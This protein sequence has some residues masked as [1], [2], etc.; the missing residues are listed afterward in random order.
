[1]AMVIEQL[2][3]S[4]E[5]QI[6][7]QLF[8]PPESHH[9][10]QSLENNN[11]QSKK[12]DHDFDFDWANSDRSNVEDDDNYS[13]SPPL[14]DG[15]DSSFIVTNIIMKGG[16]GIKE[17]QIIGD[18]KPGGKLLVCGFT[19]RG[20][21]RCMFQWVRYHRDVTFEYIEGATNPEYVVSADDV[22]KLIAVE[23]I[24]MDDHGRRVKKI[25]KSIIFKFKIYTNF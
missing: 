15:G 22:D 17:F 1:M 9:M 8:P 16:P 23:C 12:S 4:L 11:S 2:Q 5:F 18:A 24:P 7:Q 10:N 19:L 14:N 13:L 21:S 20:T 6:D 3:I 25:F